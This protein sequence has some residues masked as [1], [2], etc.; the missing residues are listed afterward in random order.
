MAPCYFV[1]GTCIFYGTRNPDDFWMYGRASD[2]DHAIRA[3][4]FLNRS[5][6]ANEQSHY[7][8]SARLMA[9][10]DSLLVE[11]TP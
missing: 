8:K 7:T 10:A 1:L 2:Q 11:V 3:A 6:V 5:K 9:Q 4:N